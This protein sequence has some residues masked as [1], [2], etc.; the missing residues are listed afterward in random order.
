MRIIWTGRASSDV[1]RLH[2]FLA[3]VNPRAASK[4]VRGLVAAPKRLLHAPRSGERLVSF[5]PRDVRRIFAGDYEV[6]YEIVEETSM[7]RA[8]GV[9]VKTA[10]Y[11]RRSAGVVG[12]LITRSIAFQRA[13]SDLP[14]R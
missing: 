11:L 9:R 14:A 2:E 4:I 1:A 6:R 5:A 10:D 12:S 8:S 7:S 13:S 3:E